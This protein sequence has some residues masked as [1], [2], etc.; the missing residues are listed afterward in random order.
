MEDNLLELSPA[1][2]IRLNQLK[3]KPKAERTQEEND[4]LEDLWADKIINTRSVR[5]KAQRQEKQRQI[6]LQTDALMTKEKMKVPL[7][8]KLADGQ[9]KLAMRHYSIDPETRAEHPFGLV[10]SSN[11]DIDKYYRRCNINE[12]VYPKKRK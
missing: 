2:E 1:E 3:E 5:Y 11:T 6:E 10:M 12:E 4:E 9:L 7:K 8:Y